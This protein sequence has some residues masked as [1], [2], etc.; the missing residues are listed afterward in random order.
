MFHSGYVVR[1]NLV[2]TRSTRFRDWPR[3]L[4]DFLLGVDG[5]WWGGGTRAGGWVVGGWFFYPLL[6]DF[7]LY[8]TS[9]G[10]LVVAEALVILLQHKR[11]IISQHWTST[12]IWQLLESSNGLETETSTLE[13][14]CSR[15]ILQRWSSWCGKL[16]ILIIFIRPFKTIFVLAISLHRL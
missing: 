13:Q 11:T 9:A 14:C 2:R 4:V 1:E 8:Q 15:I 10:L 12:I 3:S 16:I 5:L 7:L 6:V